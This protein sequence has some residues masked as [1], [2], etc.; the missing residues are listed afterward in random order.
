M[1]EKEKIR[2]F[3]NYLD[4]LTRKYD[5]VVAIKERLLKEMKIQALYDPLTGLH[6]RYALFSFLDRELERVKRREQKLLIMFI[7]LDNFKS[8]NDIYGHKMGD[9]VLRQVADILKESFRKYDIVSRFG[10]D[11]FVVA[12]MV[13]DD[14]V[15]ED[16][17]VI[18][19]RVKEKIENRFKKFGLSLSYGIAFAPEEGDDAYKLIQLADQRM[20]RMK[21]E[22]RSQTPPKSS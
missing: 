1:R 10:G 11:E 22:K 6:N 13:P 16:I 19:E 14:K 8:V 3:I 4:E 17:S 9:E 5:E 12:V 20:Y 15:I 7:D 18:I 2:I 21:R